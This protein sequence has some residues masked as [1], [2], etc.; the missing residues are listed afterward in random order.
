M[1]NFTEIKKSRILNLYKKNNIFEKAGYKIWEYHRNGRLFFRKRR[2]AD[3][4]I[5]YHN[6]ISIKKEK[7]DFKKMKEL[8][9]SIA[10]KNYQLED[11]AYF[12]SSIITDS[13]INKLKKYVNYKDSVFITMPSTSGKNIIP[14]SLTSILSHKLN[15][16]IIPQT[17]FE[18]NK[19]WKQAKKTRGIDKIIDN[20][21]Y[22]IN[23]T[24]LDK[25]KKYKNY[26]IFI[27]DDL[28]TS[29]LSVN[30]L[31]KCLNNEGFQ[32]QDIISI[33]NASTKLISQSDVNF[34]VNEA[35]RNLNINKEVAEKKLNILKEHQSTLYRQILL[36][37]KSKDKEIIKKYKNW[38]ND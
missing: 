17:I 21:E 35:V 26:K 12:L 22:K 11:V 9:Q 24:E 3:N 29:G 38:F 28:F 30:K 32:V 19:D 7:G 37:L 16:D 1:L 33:S 27:I 13:F 4:S 10:E 8:K 14:D 6:P 34:L 23:Y 36:D 15:I 18:L 20:K 5:I 2:A 25:Y 31:A